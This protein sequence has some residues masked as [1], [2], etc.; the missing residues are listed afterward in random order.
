MRKDLCG[1]G[2]VVGITLLFIGASCCTAINV[3]TAVRDQRIEKRCLT[4]I[5]ASDL[6]KDENI[7]TDN[8]DEITTHDSNTQIPIDGNP[9]STST[10]SFWIDLKPGNDHDGGKF[11]NE[12]SL[13]TITTQVT[14]DD[15]DD[16][17]LYISEW[18]TQNGIYSAIRADEDL[19]DGTT[20]EGAWCVAAAEQGGIIIIEDSK[21]YTNICTLS[22]F[23]V[24]QYID[25]T[26]P[27][28]QLTN[29]KLFCDYKMYSWD[30]DHD[31]DYV[32]FNIIIRDL[33]NN[34][35]NFFQ[36]KEHSGNSDAPNNIGYGYPGDGYCTDFWDPGNGSGHINPN[37]SI[38]D[39]NV[40]RLSNNQTLAS[41]LNAHPFN[42]K[43]SIFFWL[44]IRLYG[45]QNN[46]ELFKFW[47]DDFGIYC[48]YTYNYPPKNPSITGPISV[49]PNIAY[50]WYFSSTD[51]DYDDISYQINW[52]D[53]NI[54]DWSD[55]QP[56]GS[57]NPESHIYSDKGTYII[58]CKAKD[59]NGYESGQGMLQ[60]SVPYSSITSLQPFRE[61]I[62]GRPLH[63]FPLLRYLIG[64]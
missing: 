15:F 61:R 62:F 21:G 53:G 59:I 63:T 58:K 3:S 33:E 22:G 12:V 38:N 2:L 6:L 64:Y 42:S 54:S 8:S 20:A 25:V 37:E 30:F 55:P 40:S 52:G 32:Y 28:F 48:E 16:T 35:W 18:A 14:Q 45:L 57:T 56:S 19:W 9:P 7:N 1:K 5:D 60:I 34:I 27:N 11:E 13:W 23:S 51:P 26:L 29:A 4:S 50:S 44:D 17:D 43:H 49:K 24:D 46:K 41:Y 10:G 39:Y 47:L 36:F 31:N